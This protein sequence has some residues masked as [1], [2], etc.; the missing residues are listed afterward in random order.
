MVDI[1]ISVPSALEP[2]HAR[3]DPQMTAQA[4]LSHAQAHAEHGDMFRFGQILSVDE[5]F[6]SKHRGAP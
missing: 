2:T 5:Q 6:H 3:T 4:T 1:S